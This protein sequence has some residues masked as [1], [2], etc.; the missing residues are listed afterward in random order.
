MEDE[1]KRDIK[2]FISSRPMMSGSTSAGM[3]T[4]LTVWMAK[5][6]FPAAKAVANEALSTCDTLTAGTGVTTIFVVA[7]DSVR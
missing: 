5:L 6:I 2:Y 4:L 1:M 7:A 3:L